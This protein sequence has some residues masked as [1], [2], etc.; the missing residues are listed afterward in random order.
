MS[1]AEEIEAAA[2][3]WRVRR[4]RG[5]WSEDDQRALTAW[6]NASTAHRVAWLR[7]EYGWRRSHR[8][9]ALRLPMPQS[10]IGE[11]HDTRR[12]CH[13]YA[14]GVM[15][16]AATL[17]AVA[18]G[19]WIVWQDIGAVHHYETEIGGHRVVPLRDGSRL[20]L[21]TDTR[22]SAEID[23]RA[24]TVWLD[25]G[26][27]YFEVAHDASRPFVIHAGK[28][29]IVVLGTR[30]SVRRS[31]HDLLEVAVA[32]GR[33][34]IDA[35]DV[36][37]TEAP[38]I[39]VRG[40]VAVAAAAS[41]LVTPVSPERVDR[42]L[43]WRRG[44]LIFDNTTLA[45]AVREFNRYNRQQLMIDDTVAVARTRISGSFEA[46]NVQAFVRLLHSA[47]GLRVEDRGDRI[48]IAG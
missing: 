47:Y 11:T 23:D 12:A 38:A 15:A 21:N 27:A 26:E 7:M 37:G 25:Q 30:F 35:L 24:R 10:S 16:L 31:D 45:D 34:R 28:H 42:E 17:V 44:V 36:A 5:D 2:A 43:A 8:L 6:L 9:A 3:R 46:A 4:D 40:E 39:A 48:D 18:V 32:D 33:V 29:R 13:R 20:E 14:T 1:G 41:T 22:L 19:T